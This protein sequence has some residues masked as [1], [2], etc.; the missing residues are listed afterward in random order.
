MMKN[1]LLLLLFLVSC[2]SIAQNKGEV[3]LDWV[4]K[5]EMF[6]GDFKRV[7]PSFSNL[8][9]E[10]NDTNKSIMYTHRVVQPIVFDEGVL[11][12]TAV[13][14]QMMDFDELGELDLKAIPDKVVAELDIKKS[15]DRWDAFIHI[16][17]IVKDGLGLKKIVSFSYQINSAASRVRAENART[18]VIT[19]S[20]LASGNWY[21]FY[22]E[23]S[24][25]YRISRSFLQQLGIDVGRVDPRKIKIYG[26]G[27]RMLQL[28]N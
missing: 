8:G 14:Y 11:Q 7:I 12:I 23:K 21:R 18:N 17:P 2:G 25:A 22:I 15:R 13:N 10:Y 27:G 9:F 3:V 26:N 28:A 16:S 24:G 5:K 4:A 19:N 6:Y 20:V 1:T